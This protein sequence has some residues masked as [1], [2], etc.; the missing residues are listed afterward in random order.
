MAEDVKRTQRELMYKGTVLEI[1]K[2]H[3]EFANGNTEEWDYI[4]H[5]GAAA[6]LPVLD[7][8]RILMGRQF[9]NALDR[10]TWEIPAGKLDTP[11]E[12]GLVCAT[13]ELEEET[14]YKS[15]NLE[16]LITIRTTVALC[17]ER[18]EIYVAKDL[19]SSKQHL[20][21]NEFIDVKAFT[22]EELMGMILNQEIED[23]K[24]IA[25]VMSYAV[26]YIYK[27]WNLSW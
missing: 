13:R 3:M 11:D 1:Y 15:D 17:N 27:G 8:G 21:E 22:L 12:S 19:E 10:Y 9:R 5:N 20:D 18:I 23:S 4:H 6:V 7:D 25:S 24:T 26:K 14:G 2:D 16:L